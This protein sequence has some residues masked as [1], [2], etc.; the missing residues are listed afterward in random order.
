VLRLAFMLTTFG[1][2]ASHL[3]T[4]PESVRDGR[5]SGQIPSYQE[6]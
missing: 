5:C 1:C 4:T 3:C 2:V 6:V